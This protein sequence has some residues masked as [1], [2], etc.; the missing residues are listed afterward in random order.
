MVKLQISGNL[1]NVSLLTNINNKYSLPLIT[2]KETSAA[3]VLA[4]IGRFVDFFGWS[5]FPLKMDSVLKEIFD[6]FFG[7]TFESN[8]VKQKGIEDLRFEKAAIFLI[9]H[10]VN[11]SNEIAFSE[12]TEIS[13][14]RSLFR[15]KS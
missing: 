10:P 7:D 5:M 11:V 8:G 2:I 14:A 6:V 15:Q 13:V 9:L 12:K 3:K 4:L 1:K